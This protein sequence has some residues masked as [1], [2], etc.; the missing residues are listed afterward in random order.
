M[1]VAQLLLFAGRCSPPL[2]LSNGWPMCRRSGCRGLTAG[3][4]WAVGTIGLLGCCNTGRSLRRSRY[5]G[6]GCS[7]GT[8]AVEKR[9]QSFHGDLKPLDG[10]LITVG[11]AAHSPSLVCS[12]YRDHRGEKLRPPPVVVGRL[13]CRRS[14]A[15]DCP[16]TSISR[17]H[18]GMQIRVDRLRQSNPPELNSVYVR[19]SVISET[20]RSLLLSDLCRRPSRSADF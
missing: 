16:S 15:Q 11:L 19:R 18:P 6:H 14:H 3:A 20:K 2:W 7:L 12:K 1:T 4:V 9:C 17:P 13:A 10:P 5:E 8:Q